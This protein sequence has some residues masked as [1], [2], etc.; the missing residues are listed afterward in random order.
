MN[1]R[2]K[3]GC[4]LVLIGLVMVFAAMVIHLTQEKQD[5]LAGETAQVLLQQLQL[6]K[7]SVDVPMDVENQIEQEMVEDAPEITDMPGKDY[8]GYSMIG[9]LRVPSVGIELPILSSWSY[10]LL[11]VAPCRYTG[12]IP[13]GNM[14]LM[15]HNYKSHFT[16]LRDVVVGAEIEFEDVDGIV[17][18][19]AVAEIVQLHKTEGE[20]LPSPYPLTL[21]T[22]TPGG[23]NRVVVRCI[24][25]TE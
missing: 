3:R 9:S 14:I 7:V 11:N 12:S 23:Q 8:L 2:Q 5:T 25:I 4:I 24:Q 17:Y 20:L 19:Y 18:R 6:N 21:F 16:P 15:G 10:E 13:E 1:K 22:C